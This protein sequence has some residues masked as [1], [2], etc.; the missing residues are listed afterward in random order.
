MITPQPGEYKS[1]V[2]LDSLYIAELITDTAESCVFATPEVLAPAAE[3]SQEPTSSNETQFADDQ[4]FDTMYSEAETKITL[5]VTGLPLAIQA[6]ILG[7]GFNQATGE[8]YDVPGVPPWFALLFRSQKSN[9][10]Y[11]YF[12]FLK[13]RFAPSKEEATTK[14]AKAEPKLAELI[15]TAV[16]TTHKFSLPGG[17]TAPVKRIVGDEDAPGFDPTGWFEAVRTPEATTVQPL[18][19]AESD[20]ED[21]ETDVLV[22]ATLSLTFNNALLAGA[23][24]NVVLVAEDGTVAPAAVT[25]DETRTVVTIV[26]TSNLATDTLYI[27]TYGLVDIYGQKLSG[28]VSFT[29]VSG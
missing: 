4:P 29:T 7:K 11:K 10:K 17:V 14:G 26:P 28:A 12:A 2:G 1:V 16:N 5:K 13:G 18:A 6:K 8:M 27:V 23:V 3:A 9:G 22:N 19:L 25:L 20:P 24:N 21:G 15:F